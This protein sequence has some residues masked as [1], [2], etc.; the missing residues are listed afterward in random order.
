MDTHCPAVP[1]RTVPNARLGVDVQ[2]QDSSSAQSR[3]LFWSYAASSVKL[4]RLVGCVA[5]VARFVPIQLLRRPLAEKRTHQCTGM[6][7]VVFGGL[8]LSA[9]AASTEQRWSARL[10]QICLGATPCSHRC[11]GRQRYNLRPR[12]QVVVLEKVEQCS[13]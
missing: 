2:G 7:W 4:N 10:F 11:S 13:R 5:A 6:T 9:A 8:W 12:S 3:A 1:A